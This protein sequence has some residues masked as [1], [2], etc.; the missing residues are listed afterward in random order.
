M[1]G[2]KNLNKCFQYFQM[3]P[4]VSSTSFGSTRND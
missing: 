2:D 3:I 1:K 4:F